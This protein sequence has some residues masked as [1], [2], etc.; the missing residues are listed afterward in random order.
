MEQDVNIPSSGKIFRIKTAGKS[1]SDCDSHGSS[2]AMELY[3]KVSDMKSTQNGDIKSPEQIKT[4]QKA[5]FKQFYIKPQTKVAPAENIS[6]A[7]TPSSGSHKSAWER[8]KE[9]HEIHVHESQD[10]HRRD[11]NDSQDDLLY[12]EKWFLQRSYK[13][14]FKTKRFK[15]P[16]LEHLYQ[17]Y[18]FKLNQYNLT[19]LMGLFCVI[20]V[21]QIIFYYISGATLPM[22]GVCLGII[23]VIFIFL[24]VLCNRSS[25]D[26][27]QSSLV[28]Y[29]MAVMLCG[30][31][32][33]ITADTNPRS[34]SD[35]VWCTVLF[36]YMTYALLPIRMRL[37]VSGANC[38]V[39]IHLIISIAR[40]YQDSFAWKQVR[41]SA[42]QMG[43]VKRI[44]VF[45]HSVMTNF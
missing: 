22:R 7:H 8:A 39:L 18:F 29:V 9:A 17:R 42:E 45:E 26:Q 34:A 43:P 33:L 41:R 23:I 3:S 2:V 28:C 44:C 36:I 20:A 4:S 40:N 25:F 35:S 32:A 16:K 10:Q 11:T 38:F 15:N 5:M 37:A 13:D 21:L 24:E 1:D 6:E 14:I 19:I 27:K 31:V 12:K 30:F